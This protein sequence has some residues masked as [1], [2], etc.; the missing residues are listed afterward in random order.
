VVS[1]TALLLLSAT[2]A[3]P[4]EATFP[5]HNGRIAF[6]RD[7]G[8]STFVYTVRSNGK[9][10]RRL[11]CSRRDGQGQCHD[12]QPAW[13]KGGRYLAIAN[14]TGLAI[15]KANGEF[16]RQVLTDEPGDLGL[17]WV[18]PAWAPE[19]RRLAVT[20]AIET[21]EDSE[22]SVYI[23]NKDGTGLRRLARGPLDPAWSNRNRIALSGD[24]LV[25]ENPDG[26]KRRS[27]FNKDALGIDWSPAGRALVFDHENRLFT[28]P[29]KG[30]RAR[31]L[32][33]R[34]KRDRSDAVW[35]PDGKSIAYVRFG[36]HHDVALL[37]RKLR[38]GRTRTVARNARLPSWQARR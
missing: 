34:D 29:A 13:S 18:S 27:V 7:Q 21:T 32:V 19:G 22:Y 26:R 10:L 5:G 36:P 31:P 9:G 12:K 30:G 25:V 33:K 28:I 3:A 1:T 8:N 35:A 11:P 4:A 37:L 2:A 23:V 38:T 24:G 14:A 15:V 20:G 17:K 6:E 16:V